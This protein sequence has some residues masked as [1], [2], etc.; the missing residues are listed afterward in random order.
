M[1]MILQLARG[2]LRQGDVERERN[3][4]K[5]R[6]EARSEWS[7]GALKGTDHIH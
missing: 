2:V 4:E 3:M 7:S 6:K 5:G 1:S